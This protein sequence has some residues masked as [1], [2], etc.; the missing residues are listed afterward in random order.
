MFSCAN[1]HSGTP[2]APQGADRGDHRE[3]HFFSRIV[4][5]IILNRHR[6]E[7]QAFALEFL[8]VCVVLVVVGEGGF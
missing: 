1:A 3:W 8:D 7:L 5:N 2:G 4:P 6:S